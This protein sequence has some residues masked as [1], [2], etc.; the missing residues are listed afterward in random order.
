M[1]EVK[2]KFQTLRPFHP[3]DGAHQP[4]PLVHPDK[5]HPPFTLVYTNH[6]KKLQ[7]PMQTLVS[8]YTHNALLVS[9]SLAMCSGIH[10]SKKI[11]YVP[12]PLSKKIQYVLSSF[13]FTPTL[14]SALRQFH[15]CHQNH[16]K[17]Q[18]FFPLLQLDVESV[19]FLQAAASKLFSLPPS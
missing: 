14:H 4:L 18:Q 11:Q 1:A 16:L 5:S 3:M 2:V 8:S 13:T 10:T 9:C 19:F 7:L 15:R 12:T 17:C 6:H